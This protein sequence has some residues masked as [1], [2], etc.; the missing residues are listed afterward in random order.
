M[1]A[2]EAAA[3]WQAL[4]DK[5]SQEYYKITEPITSREAQNNRLLMVKWSYNAVD[6]YDLDRSVVS[7]AFSYFDK[8]MSLY[9]DLADF[10]CT[11][12]LAMTCLYV[13]AKVH[14]SR[15]APF[16]I[17]RLVRMSKGYF[18]RKQIAEMEKRLINILAWYMNPPIPLLFVETVRHFLYNNRNL[19]S[20]KKDQVYDM[21][22]YLIELSVCDHFFVTRRPSS[23][24]AAALHIGL[25]VSGCD[26]T[27]LQVPL[28][29]EAKEMASSCLLRMR[30]LYKLSFPEKEDASR[31]TDCS[32]TDVMMTITQSSSS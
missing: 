23:V 30:K 10:E 26:V 20:A 18:E 7:F 31:C 28:A 21:T 22:L 27:L 29:P 8:F 25:E 1:D 4:S 2:S 9:S 11:Q 5:E 17:S 12:I 19:S 32:P 3:Q 16:T 15:T 6:K 13:A 14:S 24:A